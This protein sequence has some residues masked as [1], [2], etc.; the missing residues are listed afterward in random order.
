MARQGPETRLVNRIR[1]AIKAE[2]PDAWV[3]KVHGGSYQTAGTPDLLVCVQGRLVAIEVKAP[4]P[5]ESREATYGRVTP[6]QR[7]VLASLLRA[8]A[9]AGVALSVEDALSFTALA[10]EQEET[11]PT[12]SPD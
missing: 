9:V 8:G 2:H 12:S 11:R 4:K 6:L 7:A 3:M 5:G 1:D 10:S